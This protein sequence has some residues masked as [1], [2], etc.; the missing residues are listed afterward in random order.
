MPEIA[1]VAITSHALNDTFRGEKLIKIVMISGRYLGKEPEGLDKLRDALPVRVKAVDSCGKFMWWQLRSRWSIWSTFGMAGNWTAINGSL[2][3]TEPVDPPRFARIGLQFSSGRW[4]IYLDMR[5][6]GTL[7]ISRDPDLLQAKIDTL[8]PC[9]LEGRLDVDRLTR[10]RKPIVAVLMDQCAIGAGIGNYLAAEI[11]YRAKIDPHRPG[12][13][14]TKR[15][16]QELSYWT[17]YLIKLAYYK[18]FH[19]L[20]DRPSVNLPQPQFREYHPEI[21]IS[22]EHYVHH[23]YR[24]KEDPDGNPV[25]V[26]QIVKQ[27]SAWRSTYWVPAVQK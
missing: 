13:S 22:T 23:V 11:L 24:Q 17:A 20:Q 12:S 18:N 4:A 8:E 7:K 25:Q 16:R 1:E 27:G 5:N 3:Q 21:E 15:E 19:R 14:L 2:D 10:Y 26:A 6:F 9:L